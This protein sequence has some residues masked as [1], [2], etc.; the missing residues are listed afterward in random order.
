MENPERWCIDPK[1]IKE[2]LWELANPEKES[3]V[4]VDPRVFIDEVYRVIRW[5]LS[6]RALGEISWTIGDDLREIWRI[7]ETC[8][9]ENIE[10]CTQRILEIFDYIFERLPS[11]RRIFDIAGSNLRNE[12]GE[13]HS[14]HNLYF[15]IDWSGYSYGR[16]QRVDTLLTN[17][18]ALGVSLKLKGELHFLEPVNNMIRKGKPRFKAVISKGR[19]WAN[20]KKPV[21][22]LSWEC[23]K[24][25]ASDTVRDNIIEDLLNQVIPGLGKAIVFTESVIDCIDEEY[26]VITN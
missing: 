19:Q 5:E 24:K 20:N 15:I 2:D 12:F 21:L 4:G 7:F 10:T 8:S 16:I 3:T 11:L 13:I 14:R 25:V 26:I 22:K 17:T 18:L 23:I 6:P 9:E 1:K